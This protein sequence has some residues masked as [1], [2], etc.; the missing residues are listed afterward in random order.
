MIKQP[1]YKASASPKREYNII[2]HNMEGQTDS[3]CRRGHEVYLV[4]DHHEAEGVP[5]PL[6]PHSIN[7][8]RIIYVCDTEEEAYRYAKRFT[9]D[10]RICLGMPFNDLIR[11]E[12]LDYNGVL[13]GY[14]YEIVQRAAST[15][16]S[17]PGEI[18]R[19]ESI[20]VEAQWCEDAW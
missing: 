6:C 13:I 7:V 5:E 1:N 10:R 2:F 16:L 17:V 12:L 11:E 20:W 8:S 4:L 3:N 14:G 15:E 18:V 19:R 9:E